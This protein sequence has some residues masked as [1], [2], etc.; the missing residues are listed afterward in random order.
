MMQKN[1]LILLVFNSFISPVYFFSSAFALPVQKQKSLY[2]AGSKMESL[3]VELTGKDF[4][5]SSEETLYAEL[6]TC[7]QTN[8][9]IGF[10]SR[11]QNLL[12]RFPKGLYVDNALYLSGQKYLEEKKYSLAL[13]QF[14]IVTSQFASSNKAVSAQFAKA[15]TYKQMNLDS[16]A[17]KNFQEVI[18][19]FPGSPEAYRAEN[20]LKLMRVK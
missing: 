20:E 8:D 14:A 7:Y 17:S 19:K 11:L 6:V 5:K 13:K 16:F 1:I 12:T 3:L 18:K 15:F 2:Q 4:S 9:S 10:Q